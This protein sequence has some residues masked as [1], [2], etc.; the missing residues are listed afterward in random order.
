MVLALKH[1]QGFALL[2]FLQEAMLCAFEGLEADCIVP[3]PLHPA[4]LAT[5]G[6]NQSLELARGLARVT[7][8]PLM[9]QAVLRD[10]DTPL[11]AGLRPRE[12]R[13]A[14]RGA[15]RCVQSFEGQRVLVI[16]DVMTSGSTLHELA[17]TLKLAGA[18]KVS[19]L[20]LARASG[21]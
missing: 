21:F 4:R 14:V 15:F 12:R 13:R 8:L 7:D 1:G 5:R 20:V 17:R 3:M 18:A 19:N 6:Y 9:W 16:D 11:L 10:I 2:P